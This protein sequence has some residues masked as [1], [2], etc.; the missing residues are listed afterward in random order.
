M[1]MNMKMKKYKIIIVGLIFICVIL[2]IPLII[3]TI[4]KYNNPNPIIKDILTTIKPIFDEKHS[5]VLE[6]INGQ[7][8]LN[9]IQFYEDKQSYTINK[10]TVYLCLKDKRGKYY[11]KNMLIY[12]TLHEIAHVI[13]DE[14]GHTNKFKEIFDELIIEAVKKGIYNPS[15]PV[16]QNYCPAS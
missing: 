14:V 8:I 11:N 5:G 1:K 16:V 3:R 12:V 10:N 15:I 4:E 9:K 13:C 6:H 7:D 2:I